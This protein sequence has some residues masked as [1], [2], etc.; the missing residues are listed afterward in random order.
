VFLAP[1]PRTTPRSVSLDSLRCGSY[2]TDGRRLF[3]VVSQFAPAGE[4]A[5]ASLEDCRTLRV[6]AYAPGELQAMKLKTIRR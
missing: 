4:D 3:R 2:L 5:F 1:R 6:Q